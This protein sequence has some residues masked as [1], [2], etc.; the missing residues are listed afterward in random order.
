MLSKAKTR[1][2]ALGDWFRRTLDRTDL[3]LLEETLHLLEVGLSPI[4]RHIA[5][6]YMMNRGGLFHD[7]Y[8]NWRIRRCTKILEI[9]GINYFRG[10]KVLEVGAGHGDL[11]AFFA[12]LGADVLCLDG[13]VQNV[14]FGSL[15]YR[16][17]ANIRFEQHNLEEDF[18][19]FGRFDLIINLG[20]IY[21]LRNVD[22][23][24]KC[25]FSVADDIVLETIVCD[26]TDP[27]K[28]FYCKERREI[29]EESLEGVGSRPS[30]MYIERIAEEN[31]FK[32]FRYF[33][34]DLNSGQETPDGYQFRYDWE[35]KNDDSFNNHFN[36]P[37]LRRFWRFGLHP[38]SQ[39]PS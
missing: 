34:S 1:L 30:P 4:D 20:L 12:D 17:L 16:K 18:S 3:Q 13:R 11:G 31:G 35:H 14:I 5:C 7:A 36:G 24:L 25:C 6:S 19:S 8:I 15:K 10:K 39:T 33:T 21:H 9:Y 26:S 38:V 2:R 29:D 32:I 27:Y 23:H 22:S 37:D 28:I